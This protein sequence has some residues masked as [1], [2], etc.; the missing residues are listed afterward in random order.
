MLDW[1]MLKAQLT[2][3]L[4][5]LPAPATTEKALV[6][7]V[8]CPEVIANEPAAPPRRLPLMLLSAKLAVGRSDAST[9]VNVMEPVSNSL[10][11]KPE[12]MKPCRASGIASS[13]PVDVFPLVAAA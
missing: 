7:A 6:M 9:S 8:C 11:A 4:L 3:P 1:L 12:A 13:D 10:S 5:S 2:W